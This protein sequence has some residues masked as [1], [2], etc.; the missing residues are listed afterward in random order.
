[1]NPS[2]TLA[3]SLSN[4]YTNNVTITPRA[5]LDKEQRDT[6]MQESKDIFTD[7]RNGNLDFVT[8]TLT[9]QII[10]LNNITAV[11]HKKA[12]GSGYFKEFTELSVKATDQLRK[13]A[14]ALAQIKNVIVNIENLTLQQ[15]N[16]IQLNQQQ[17][18]KEVIDAK[19][20]VTAK[21]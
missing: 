16:Y 2:Q 13:S 18:Q 1:M 12:K 5:G 19:T 4:L 10:L 9:T 7:I 11:C 20:V 8:D 21:A 15:N 3:D 6:V 14:L 17:K